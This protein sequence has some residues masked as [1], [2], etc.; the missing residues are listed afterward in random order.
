MLLVEKCNTKRNRGWITSC[1]LLCILLGLLSR[2]TLPLPVFF[3]IY[4]G[5]TLWASMFYFIFLWI[6]PRQKAT[7]IFIITILFAFA[8][9]FSQMIDV[10]WL[11]ALRQTP[12][13]LLLG[14]GFLISDLLC[15]VGGTVLAYALDLFI[16]YKKNQHI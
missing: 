10:A 8:I 1:I 2:S 12:L 3:R 16:C 11:N 4:G 13:R 14:Q 6:W 5:D 9:E 15:Y 7:L